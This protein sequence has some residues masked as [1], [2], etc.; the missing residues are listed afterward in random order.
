MRTSAAA[1]IVVTLTLW[2]G[3]DALAHPTVTVRT[4]RAWRRSPGL[5]LVAAS[6]DFADRSAAKPKP[7]DPE[8][9]A[10]TF[11]DTAFKRY[12]NAEDPNVS[13]LLMEEAARAIW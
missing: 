5:R 13:K 6:G 8:P 7:S 10:T 12:E 11:V 3:S 1:F 2:R 4:A 9:E